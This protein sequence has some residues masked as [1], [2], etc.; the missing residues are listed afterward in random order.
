MTQNLVKRTVTVVN[1]QGIH[2]RPADLFV[3]QANQFES[4]IEVIKDGRRVDGK[5]IILLLTLAAEQGT[6]LTI[7]ATGD[8][9]RT[10][11]E[12]LCKLIENGFAEQEEINPQ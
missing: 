12:V 4:E 2:A 3:N 8:D 10:A 7:E 11:L 5:S 1:P 9:A 6:K